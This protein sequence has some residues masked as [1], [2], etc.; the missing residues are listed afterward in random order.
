MKGRR[1][2][3]R[4]IVI[5]HTVA[6]QTGDIRLKLIKAAIRGMEEWALYN[7]EREAEQCRDICKDKQR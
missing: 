5:S 2:A 3:E 4:K 1:K 7:E 6:A